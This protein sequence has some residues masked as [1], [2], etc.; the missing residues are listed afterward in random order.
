MPV[1]SS[2]QI[3]DFRNVIQSGSDVNKRIHFSLGLKRNFLGNSYF[4]K[5]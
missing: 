1:K 2:S 3:Y 5:S 4:F